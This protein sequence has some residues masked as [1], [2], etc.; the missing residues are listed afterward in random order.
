M[1]SNDNSLIIT[2][3][4]ACSHFIVGLLL[5]FETVK[6]LLK[7][8][9]PGTGHSRRHFDFLFVLVGNRV[10]LI[11]VIA[12]TELHTLRS[13]YVCGLIYALNKDRTLKISSTETLCTK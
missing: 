13:V 10:A 8:Q 4:H 9:I 7:K 12:F 3:T 5:N 2:S 6:S 11:L 1:S